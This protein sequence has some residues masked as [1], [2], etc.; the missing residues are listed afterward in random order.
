MTSLM[1]EIKLVNLKYIADWIWID[2]LIIIFC[3]ADE[4]IPARDVYLVFPSGLPNCQ[5]TLFNQS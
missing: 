4:K 2:W 1:S 3:F 5:W